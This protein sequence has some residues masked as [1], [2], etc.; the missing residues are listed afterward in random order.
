MTGEI[1]IL[2][3]ILHQDL[4][5]WLE[6]NQN[7]EVFASKFR[8]LREYTSEHSLQFK[9]DIARPFDNKTKYYSRLILN[10]VKSEFDRSYRTIDEDRNENLILYHLNNILNKRLKTHLR[11]IGNLIKQKDYELAYIDTKN[12]SYQ[13]DKQHKADTYVMQ[14]LKLGYM[15]LY[16]EVQEAFKDWVYD[17]FIVED[18][19]TQLLN[20]PIPDKLPIS[21]IQILQIEP[22]PVQKT[23]TKKTETSIQFNSFFYKQF[24]TN[25]DKINDLWNSLK[26]NNFISDDTPLPTFKKIFSGK[27]PEEPIKWIGYNN[28]LYYFIKLLHNDLKLVENLN[29][30][31]WEITC[32]C[33]VDKEGKT[34]EQSSFRGMKRPSLTANTLER[35]VGLLE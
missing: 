24:N 28:A 12:T 3:D 1:D 14:L 21:K 18:F 2:N 26:L 9:I 4:R 32:K 35:I 34:F 25:P 7:D 8:G 20:E 33:F 15:Q 31:H 30:R 10:A 17:E 19:Y 23:K 27:K 22:E 5:P 13:I 11:D 16:L 6:H 29:H